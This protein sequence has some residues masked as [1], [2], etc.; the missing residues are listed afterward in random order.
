MARVYLPPPLRASAGGLEALEGEFATVAEALAELARRF[1]E[2]YRRL[3]RG[4]GQLTSGWAVVVDGTAA[5]QGVRAAL[6]PTS[7]VHILP[8]LGGG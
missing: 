5:P 1:P 4:D 8:A 2:A 3:T 6:S 7:E